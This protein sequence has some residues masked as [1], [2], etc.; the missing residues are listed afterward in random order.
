VV[1]A[2]K[3]QHTIVAL[4]ALAPVMPPST[5]V[6]CAQNGVSN[7][8]AVLR[9]FPNVYAVSVASP[10]GHLTPGV[11][12]AYSSPVTGIGDL[13]RFPSGVDTLAGSVAAALRSSTFDSVVRPDIMAWKWAKL[14]LNL[15]NAVE[16][17]CGPAGRQSPIGERARAEG[18]ACLR[19]AAIP[20]VSGA[21]D[22]ARRGD[23]VRPHRLDGVERPGGSSWQSL[24]RA[25]GDVEAD[26]LNG[27]I[28][29]LGRLHGV[30]TPVNE[31]L[32]RQAN[33]MARLGTPPGSLTPEQFLLLLDDQD[34]DAEAG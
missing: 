7:E 24:A 16:A 32:Q 3:S 5:P 4:D 28:V 31:L 18:V 19:A 20:F 6:L 10:C 9:R 21:D 8:R 25:T 27:E 22:R 14:L 15:G 23:L 11:V 33:A 1:L 29:L 30:A 2:M 12:Q 13:G 17:V 34:D 26:Y